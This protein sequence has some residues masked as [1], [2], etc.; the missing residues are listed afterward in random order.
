M[1][2]KDGGADASL[3]SRTRVVPEY[4]PLIYQW[5]LNLI[6]ALSFVH[7]H[8]VVFGDLCIGTCWVS[9]PPSL[10]LS[11][12]G[13]V[14]ASFRVASSGSLAEG[15]ANSEEPFHP[16]NLQSRHA[17]VPTMKTDLFLWGCLVY[18]LMTSLWPGRGSGKSD[19]EI[20]LAIAQRRW[21]ELEREHLGDVVRKC[22]E[23]AYEDAQAAKG[24]LV[25]FL[26]RDGLQVRD[27]DEL[28]GFQA[29]GIFEGV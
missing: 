12:V 10:A 3:P 19:A 27:G 18:E 17:V 23:Y 20:K 13:F 24:D 1:Y 6:S 4:R 7:S 14:N 8:E 26:S 22:W 2:A 25:A 11:L 29:A 9:A 16:L 21:P 28:Q 15:E 5:A